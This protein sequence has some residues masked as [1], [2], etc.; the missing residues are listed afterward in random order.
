[1]SGFTRLP[2]MRAALR[3]S[4]IGVATV[5]VSGGIVGAAAEPDRGNRLEAT[6]TETRL[7]V[8][9][10]AADL[11]IRQVISRG[12]GTVDGFGAATEISAVS[13]DLAATPCGPGSSTSTILRRIVVSE[14]TLVLKT[15]AHRCPIPTGILATGEYQVDGASSTGVFA[16][17]W[18]RGG[19]KVD[20]APPPSGAIMV[21][22]SGKLHLAETGD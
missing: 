18:G 21:T 13:I 8:Q 3:I 4:L 22:I 14:G 1:M 12:I 2:S 9:D 20:V 6:F 11:G 10:R 15:L 17:A 7:A 16:G 5:L 19:E